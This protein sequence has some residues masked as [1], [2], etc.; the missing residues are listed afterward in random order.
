MKQTNFRDINICSRRK[1]KKQEIQYSGYSE[2]VEKEMR[3]EGTG[4]TEN[5][6]LRILIF[7]LN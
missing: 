6:R 2:D 7:K 1:T 4:Y 3:R 5:F